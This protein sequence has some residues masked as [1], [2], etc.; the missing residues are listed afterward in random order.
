MRGVV[1]KFGV[2]LAVLA[3]LSG[4][5]QVAAVATVCNGCWACATGQ[6]NIGGIGCSG[7][8]L[9]LAPELPRS[10]TELPLLHAPQEGQRY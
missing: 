9:G 8:S 10:T 6:A 2:V 5:A 7:A 3:A 1:V 4:C